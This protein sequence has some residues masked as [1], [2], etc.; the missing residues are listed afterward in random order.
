MNRITEKIKI[1]KIKRKLKKCGEGGY[2]NPTCHG[3]FNNVSLGDNCFIGAN[4]DFNCLRAEVKIGNHVM[5]AE[6][7][8]FITGD[9][10]YNIVGKYLD[11]ITNEMKDPSYDQDIVIEDDVW[12]GAR[13]IILKGVTIHKGAIV[14][15]GAVVTKD[16]PPYAIVGGVPAKVISYR[17]NEEEIK[18]HEKLLA[19]RK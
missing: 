16:V 4:N 6:D 7:V 17:F 2:I 13:V 8:I 11:E 5:T 19:N 9:H 15:A 18:E 3:F 1:R 14:A 10:Q 12:I